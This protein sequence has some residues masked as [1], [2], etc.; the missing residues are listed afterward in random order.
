VVVTWNLRDALRACLRSL[1]A[2]T[3]RRLEILVVDNCSTDG[4]IEMVRLEFPAVR[5]LLTGRNL[6]FAEGAN[7]GIAASR[8][9][10]V[11]TLNNDAIVE[12][13][14]AAALAAAAAGAEPRCG[15]LQSL[16]LYQ[17]R[18]GTINSSGLILRGDGCG[19]DRDEGAAAETSSSI[20][21]IF[22]PTAGAAAYRRTML[23]ELR[24]RAG[25]FDARHFMY[26]EDLDLGW[27]AR[28]RG[29]SARTVP[30][31]VVH[32]AWHASTVRHGAR[33][34][35]QIGEINRL[36]TLLKNASL[37]FLAA[38][39]VRSVRGV[40]RLLRVGGGAAAR[41]LAAAVLQSVA[42][43]SRATVDRRALEASW[44]DRVR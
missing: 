12:P 33:W 2:Q 9:S 22:C 1:A 36:R 8:A 5:L 3:H 20:E 28:L 42:A 32:H 23:E 34:L 25:Y 4:S 11:V 16:M 19:M 35:I 14:W 13:G 44:V 43:R 27:R 15:M 37:R 40:G 10:W 38:T 24:G 7:L 18:P 39:S 26:Y 6:G 41:R 31:A 30:G 29:W 17:F 21:E